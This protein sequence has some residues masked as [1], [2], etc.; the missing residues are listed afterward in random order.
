M[1]HLL[2]TN[3]PQH[4]DFI[5]DKTIEICRPFFDSIRIYQNGGY[6]NSEIINGV[7][8]GG[9]PTFKDFIYCQ[10][11]LK[12]GIPDGDWIFALDSDER[13]SMDLLLSLEGYMS[14]DTNTVSVPFK[15]HSFDNNGAIISTYG[16]VDTFRPSRMFKILPGLQSMV[17][18]SAHFGYQQV[19]TNELQSPHFINHYKHEFATYLST[20]SF[21]VSLP[22][23]IGVT[24]SMPEF[25]VIER[26]KD[27][28]ESC[29]QEKC[30]PS[31]VYEK[32]NNK[33]F[34]KSL[35]SLAG[36]FKLY[37]TCVNIALAIEFIAKNTKPLVELYQHDPCSR[38][39]CN[40]E[41]Y[42]INP[43]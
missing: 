15:H 37:P 29:F 13:P 10:N 7:T 20:L 9:S 14:T 19:Q 5:L 42:N 16:E 12:E 18:G 38:T 26:F 28:F 31:S 27:T 24:P 36:D 2:I 39:C 3:G 30:T 33:T 32:F 35:Y 11:F 34:W 40:Y 8:I 21:G 43:I 23:S 6:S 1:L 22:D 41:N 17:A 25:A 4:R